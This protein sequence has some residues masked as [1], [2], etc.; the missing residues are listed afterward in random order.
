MRRPGEVGNGGNC[1]LPLRIDRVT[2][3]TESFV[4]TLYCTGVD[5]TE[6]RVAID[7]VPATGRSWQTNRWYR[8]DGIARS[9]TLEA[10]LLF[11][12]GDGSA[13]RIDEPESRTRP[14]PTETEDPWLIQLGTSDE[15]LGVTVQVRP[16][17]GTTSARADDPESFEIGAVCFASC[18]GTDDATVYH[19]EE[20]GSRDEQLLLEHVANDLSES[21]GATLVTHGTDPSP[22]EMLH[23]R[24][25]RAAGGDVVDS[26]AE[27]VLDAQ[28]HANLER[29]AARE[30]LDTLGSAAE[31]LDIETSPVSLADYDIGLDPVDWR[32]GWEVDTLSLSSVSDPRMTDRDYATLLERYLDADDGSLGA[33]ELA[34]C[35]KAY[36]GSDCS[37][38]CTLVASDAADQL[39]CPRLA[40][41]LSQQD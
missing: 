28:F 26:G 8:F 20:P 34:R 3:D 14:S 25:D 39:A 19:R 13:D 11:P 17:D 31:R 15:V 5:G 29:V 40:G 32:D 24:L 23:A 33:T 7:G 10:E 16:T 4:Q 35:L 22:L 41:R 12:P 6:L 27:R 30:E 36:A 21:R 9:R 1:A 2:D 37:L 38:L 18:D